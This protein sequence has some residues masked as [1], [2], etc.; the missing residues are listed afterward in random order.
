[1]PTH[2]QTP[3]ATRQRAQLSSAYLAPE[4]SGLLVSTHLLQQRSS[5]YLVV[6]ASLRP[7]R[8]YSGLLLSTQAYSGVLTRRGATGRRSHPLGLMGHRCARREYSRV[9]LSIHGAPVRCPSNP[10]DAERPIRKARRDGIGAAD[11]GELAV[12]VYGSWVL[13]LGTVLSRYSGRV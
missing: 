3:S 1:V 9:G 7:T 10:I 4:Y 12:G 6:G 8:E 11:R 13:W 2:T 5:A